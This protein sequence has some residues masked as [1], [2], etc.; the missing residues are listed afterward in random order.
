M[1]TNKKAELP[2]L[3][4]FMASALLF[5]NEGKERIMEKGKYK[6]LEHILKEMLPYVNYHVPVRQSNEVVLGG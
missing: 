3:F 6:Y 1:G 5:T 4:G 2:I